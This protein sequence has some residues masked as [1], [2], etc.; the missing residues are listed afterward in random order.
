M[1]ER[2]IQSFIV[3]LLRAQIQTNARK[4][5]C[6][7]ISLTHFF[8]IRPSG[9]S[10]APLSSTR[11]SAPAATAASSISDRSS[12]CRI[13]RTNMISLIP[14]QHSAAPAIIHDVT[15]K[16]CT[17]IAAASCFRIRDDIWYL[18]GTPGRRARRTDE[19]DRSPLSLASVV[20][21]TQEI[22]SQ[23]TQNGCLW[24][25]LAL[26]HANTPAPH[27]QKSQVH[28]ARVVAAQRPRELALTV[29]S[30]S[31]A[32]HHCSTAALIATRLARRRIAAQTSYN[33]SPREESKQ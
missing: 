19:G 27:A 8:T 32:H 23:Q 18:W 2:P 10:T 14:R 12:F 24:L 7:L 5:A 33:N 21:S 20:A 26:T 1:P 25:R 6:Q 29:V 17:S 9:M 30:T 4:R 13:G 22:S 11:G 28:T 16:R 31:A 3:Q 15:G